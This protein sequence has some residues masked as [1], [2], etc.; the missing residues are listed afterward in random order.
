MQLDFIDYIKVNKN[1]NINPPQI[2]PS[3]LC[4]L[5]TRK[6]LLSKSTQGTSVFNSRVQLHFQNTEV[7]KSRITR[8]QTAV[9]DF[10]ENGHMC[11]SSY[12]Q[13]VT[14]FSVMSE[15]CSRR[16]PPAKK[17]WKVCKKFLQSENKCHTGESL[18]GSITFVSPVFWF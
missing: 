15:S 8:V 2:T 11:V 7:S 10:P 4:Q 5:F 14:T 12:L 16:F 18:I 1:N 3:L 9:M 17:Y 13:I 6:Y